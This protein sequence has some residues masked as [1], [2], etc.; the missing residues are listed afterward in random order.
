MTKLIEIILL[1]AVLTLLAAPAHS[2]RRFIA[3]PLPVDTNA[4]ETAAKPVED[5]PDEE[6]SGAEASVLELLAFRPELPRTLLQFVQTLELAKPLNYP[7][8]Q[9]AAFLEP[10]ASVALRLEDRVNSSRSPATSLAVVAA[11]RR[12][13]APPAARPIA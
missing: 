7:A 5:N 10:G 1:A 3:P 4:D 11:P 12:P 2:V 6:R 13:H 9:R 8:Q